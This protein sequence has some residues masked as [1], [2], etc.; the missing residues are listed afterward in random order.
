MIHKPN[1][2]WE[3][4]GTALLALP[5]RN[6]VSPESQQN[7]RQPDQK[8]KVQLFAGEGRPKRDRED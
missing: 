3:T 7:E 4:H 6:P 8:K 5:N 1:R 2:H